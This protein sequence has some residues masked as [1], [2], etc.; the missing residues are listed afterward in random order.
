MLFSDREGTDARKPGRFLKPIL[1]LSATP[2]LSNVT[3]DISGKVEPVSSSGAGP[4]P[5]KPVSSLRSEL[6]TARV[7]NGGAL[8]GGGSESAHGRRWEQQ[9]AEVVRVLRLLQHVA[10]SGMVRRP[11]VLAPPCMYVP[12]TAPCAAI[13]SSRRQA[14]VASALHMQ[15][16]RSCAAGLKA[17]VVTASY[18]PTADMRLTGHSQS[19][20]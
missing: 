13:V 20:H 5:C 12:A 3:E 7:Q 15:H 16:L 14:V 17:Q 6:S 4:P 1:P 2:N 11:G 18:A 8:Q 10:A 19:D 9:R